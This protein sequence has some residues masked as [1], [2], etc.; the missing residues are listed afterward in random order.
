[1]SKS[2]SYEG[3]FKVYCWKSTDFGVRSPG[4]E[5]WFYH[6]YYVNVGRFTHNLWASTPTAEL[7]GWQYSRHRTAVGNE[8]MHIRCLRLCLACKFLDNKWCHPLLAPQPLQ[9]LESFCPQG[10][11][12]GSLT[13]QQFHLGPYMG[14]TFLHFYSHA[15]IFYL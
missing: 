3:E 4:T 10:S 13:T 9:A 1:M 8:I 5:C 11:I 12:L 7:L 2:T 15:E 14:S 6:D